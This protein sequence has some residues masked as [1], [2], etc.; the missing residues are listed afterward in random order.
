MGI[1][2]ME[3]GVY[4]ETWASKWTADSEE[5]DLANIPAVVNVVYLAFAKPDNT[6]VSGQYTFNGTG[7]NFSQSFD[8]S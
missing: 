8:S 3:V 5:M 6:Y 2:Q 7:L 1:K 4:F